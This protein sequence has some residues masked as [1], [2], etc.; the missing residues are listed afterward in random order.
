[1]S[2]QEKPIRTIRVYDVDDSTEGYRVLVDRIWP[3]GVSKEALG[4][5][6]WAKELAPSTDSRKWFGH[7]P[8][9]WDEFRARYSDELSK[10]KRGSSNAARGR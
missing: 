4:L 10:I 6:Q 8:E 7:A 3:R 1:M 5:D 2:K 9:K